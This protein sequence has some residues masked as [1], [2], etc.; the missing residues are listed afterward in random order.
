MAELE[1]FFR[2]ACLNAQPV[3]LDQLDPQAAVLYPILLP[4]RLEV[5]LSLPQQPLLHRTTA[6][7]QQDVVTIVNKLKEILQQPPANLHYS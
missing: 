7:G 5:I 6:V 1:N 2:A 4:D 3:Q